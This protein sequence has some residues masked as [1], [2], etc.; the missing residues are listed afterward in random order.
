MSNLSKRGK[1]VIPAE[2][3]IHLKRYYLGSDMDSGLRQN[4]VIRLNYGYCHHE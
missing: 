3:G 4:D 2:A 1:T